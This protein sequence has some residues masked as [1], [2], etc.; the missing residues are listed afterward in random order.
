MQFNKLPAVLLVSLFLAL[1]PVKN[2]GADNHNIHSNTLLNKQELVVGIFPRR[3]SVTTMRLFR[4][5]QDYLSERLNLKVRIETTANFDSFNQRLYQNRYDMVHLNQYQY[6]KAH[7]DL[8]YQVILQNEEFG[9]ASIRGAIYVRKD[10]GIGKVA[11][12]KG[13]DILF[14]GGEQAMMSYIVPTFLLNQH[15]LEKSDYHER[16]SNNPPN[17]VLAT[18]LKQTEAAGAGAIVMQLPMVRK[19]IEPDALTYLTVSQPLAHLPWAVHKD[20]SASLRNRI[21]Q[22]LIDLSHSKNGIA[23]LKAARLTAFNPATE[24]NYTRHREIID[25]VEALKAD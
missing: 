2:A 13:K 17:A 10:S 12:L 11:D 8:G 24:D 20:M 25:V 14:G 16:F 18:Y 4:P 23:I 1:N 9:Q 22:L 7:D 3:D 15:G 6:V 5:L 21:R 19:R